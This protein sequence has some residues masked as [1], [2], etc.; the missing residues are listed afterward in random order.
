MLL[1][2]SSLGDGDEHTHHDLPLVLAGGKNC[3]I[4]G[5]RHIRYA[6]ETPMNNLLLA[7]LHK[8]DLPAGGEFRG[9][10]G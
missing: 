1:F 8:A 4:R 5:G 6:P 2:G 9:F 7:M 3:K 10:P